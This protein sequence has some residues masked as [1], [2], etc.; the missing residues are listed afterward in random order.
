M[1][2]LRYGA[3]RVVEVDD[4]LLAHLEPV[5]MNKLARGEPFPLTLEDGDGSETFWITERAHVEIVYAEPASP[6][7]NQR[8]I[9][10]LAAVAESPAGL[11]ATPEP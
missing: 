6:A 4:R 2:E 3:G 5:I 9:H 8:W 7:L 11:W 1:G 10:E